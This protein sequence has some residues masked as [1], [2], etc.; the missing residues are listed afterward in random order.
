MFYSNRFMVL[1]HLFRLLIHLKLIFAD[2][3]RSSVCFTLQ[4]VKFHTVGNSQKTYF[5]NKTVSTQ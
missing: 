4:V 2:G 3:M 1:E 5:K